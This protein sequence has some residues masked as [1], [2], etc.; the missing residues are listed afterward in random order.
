MKDKEGAKFPFICP[1][2]QC[3][4]QLTS[5]ILLF[6]L[7]PKHENRVCIQHTSSI[8]VSFEITNASALFQFKT[9]TKMNRN[10]YVKKKQQNRVKHKLFTLFGLKLS[11][12]FLCINSE[13]SEHFSSKESCSLVAFW[14]GH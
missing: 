12:I 13:R 3:S 8:I 7:T 11:D 1:E 2:H 9:K 6:D 4:I 5:F 14:L 10:F